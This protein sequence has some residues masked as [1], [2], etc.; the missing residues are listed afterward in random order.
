MFESFIVTDPNILNQLKV[1]AHTVHTAHG[2]IS[3]MTTCGRGVVV[4]WLL[5]DTLPT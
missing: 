4:G 1:H 3:L 5:D 2:Q